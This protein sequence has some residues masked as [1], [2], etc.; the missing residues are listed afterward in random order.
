V[1]RF[2]FFVLLS[3]SVGCLGQEKA[4]QVVQVVETNE[5]SYMCGVDPAEVINTW[6]EVHREPLMAQM[7][8]GPVIM[9]APV[10]E[11]VYYK[12]PNSNAR[13]LYANAVFVGTDEGKKVRG[14]RCLDYVDVIYIV[15][16]QMLV[17][18]YPYNVRDHC[19]E[20]GDME[21]FEERARK[22]MK[23]IFG[24]DIEVVHPST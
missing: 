16:D 22:D 6:E 3:L 9:Y 11:D 5:Y 12:N 10:G 21:K 7:R 4:Q 18:R 20:L 2:L 19:F 17:Q 23:R 14:C 1:L 8:M 13:F 15:D 24:I